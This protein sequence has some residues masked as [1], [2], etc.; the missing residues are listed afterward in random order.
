MSPED[1]EGLSWVGSLWTL[2][3][4]VFFYSHISLHPIQAP[5]RLVS[6]CQAM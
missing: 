3:V 4:P 2:H 6:A 1:T 5:G